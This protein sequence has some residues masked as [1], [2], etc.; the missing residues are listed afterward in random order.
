MSC[1]LGGEEERPFRKTKTPR[2]GK[3]KP[4]DLAGQ[5]ALAKYEAGFE[6]EPSDPFNKQEKSPKNQMQRQF[7]RKALVMFHSYPFPPPHGMGGS[8][9]LSWRGWVGTSFPSPV[10]SGTRQ[11]RRGE[12]APAGPAAGLGQSK[13]GQRQGLALRSQGGCREPSAPP[14][15]GSRGL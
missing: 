3:I 8:E 2:I 13:D 11:L 9:R 10:L 4:K 1:G 6:G 14:P 15:G 7:L 12:A 5:V